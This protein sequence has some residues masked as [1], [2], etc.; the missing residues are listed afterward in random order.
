MVCLGLLIHV[1][2]GKITKKKKRK[3][4]RILSPIV[5]VITTLK[6]EGLSLILSM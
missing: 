6:R 5:S 4:E 3:R 2:E 1:K